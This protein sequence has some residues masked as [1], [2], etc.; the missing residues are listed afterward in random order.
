MMEH[1]F[2]QC[3][4]LRFLFSRHWQVTVPRKEAAIVIGHSD[5]DVRFRKARLIDEG[6]NGDRRW[7]AYE[8]KQSDLA[9]EIWIAVKAR[10]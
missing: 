8:G 6:S 4:R 10:R 1:F 7:A 3:P 9:E 2:T 5:A